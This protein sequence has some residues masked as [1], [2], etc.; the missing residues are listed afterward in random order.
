MTKKKW[1]LRNE[2]FKRAG[3]Y[4]IDNTEVEVD[5]NGE[6]ECDRTS[7]PM[8]VFAKIVPPCVQ[9]LS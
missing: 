5:E 1:R 2:Y 7:F 3:T 8:G 9:E 6:F 4:I